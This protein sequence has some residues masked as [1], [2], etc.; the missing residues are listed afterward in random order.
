MVPI[1]PPTSWEAS[2]MSTE[3]KEFLIT[4]PAVDQDVALWVM[5]LFKNKVYNS[6]VVR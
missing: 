3:A 2:V 6:L 4:S 1:R 5:E